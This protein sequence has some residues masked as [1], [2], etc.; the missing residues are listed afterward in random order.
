MDVSEFI[1]F[2]ESTSLK[3]SYLCNGTVPSSRKAR[4]GTALRESRTT[5]EAASD[6]RTAGLSLA[7]EM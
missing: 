7:V 5:I 6:P 1:S 4:K 2:H 3:E